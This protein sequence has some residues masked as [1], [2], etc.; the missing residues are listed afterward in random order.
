MDRGHDEKVIVT[1]IA[2]KDLVLS[3]MAFEMEAQVAG[4]VGVEFVFDPV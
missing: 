3:S 1:A 4:I 2:A